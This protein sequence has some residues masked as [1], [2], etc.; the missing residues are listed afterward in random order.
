MKY[1][2]LF[3]ESEENEYYHGISWEDYIDH[4]DFETFDNKEFDEISTLAYLNKS[5][6]DMKV[7]FD[8]DCEPRSE[9]VISSK[10]GNQSINIFKRVD[11]WYYVKYSTFDN[12]GVKSIYFYKCDQFEGLINLLKEKI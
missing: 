6:D 2:K 8:E 5:S 12:R 3:N 10:N 11:E 1:L 4:F 9:I 7:E